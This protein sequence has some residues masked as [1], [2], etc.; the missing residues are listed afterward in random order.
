MVHFSTLL[1][2]PIYL[3]K[4]VRNAEKINL[5]LCQSH[6][7]IGEAKNVDIT[8]AMARLFNEAYR[9]MAKTEGR[10]IF[11]TLLNSIQNKIL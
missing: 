9:K 4:P 3:M 5:Q 7:L 2:K 6:F 11:V 1:L 10:F 8:K